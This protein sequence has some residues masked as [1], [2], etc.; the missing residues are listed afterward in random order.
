MYSR[1]TSLIERCGE[2]VL[3]A[4][5]INGGIIKKPGDANYVTNYDIRVQ[6]LLIGALRDILPEAQYIAEES[7]DMN[8]AQ[9]KLE[10]GY[11]FVIDPIDGTTNFIKGFD[12]S[13]ISVA[14]CYKSDVIFG[15]V[16]NPYTHQMYTARRGGGAYLNGKRINVHEGGLSSGIVS[17]G[18][19]PYHRE[20]T[21]ET[22]RYVREFLKVS[23]D[24]RRT[25]SAALDLCDVACR[26]SNLFFELEL[27]PWDYAAGSLIVSE[28]GGVITT[29]DNGA[30]KF[31]RPC[32]VLAGTPKAH[33][34]ALQL[35][36]ACKRYS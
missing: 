14:L 31:D 16:Y 2:I 19:T 23:M 22:L 21:A 32:S 15:A 20:R 1:I 27:N 12:H 13:A 18:T 35:F 24:I 3:S 33:K 6:D 11:S 9:S 7:D 36:E 10:S 28:A 29:L 5:D 8:S 17:F 34:E 30:L 26:R 4:R 25:G